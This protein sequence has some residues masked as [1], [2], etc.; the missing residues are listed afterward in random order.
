MANWAFEV[1]SIAEP[2]LAREVLPGASTVTVR[3]LDLF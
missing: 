3:L 2:R 1:G